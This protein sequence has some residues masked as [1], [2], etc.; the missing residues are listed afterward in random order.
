[1]NVKA[2]TRS[3]SRSMK[4]AALFVI[5]ASATSV[6][7]LAQEPRTESFLGNLAPIARSIQFYDVPHQFNV[8][9]QEDA[10]DWLERWLKK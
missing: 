10:F 2:V 9:M 7:L 5:L 6:S 3:V 8:Q 4:C 1:M